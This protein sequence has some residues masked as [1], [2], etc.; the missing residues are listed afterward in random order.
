VRVLQARDDLGLALEPAHEVGVV[1]EFGMDG[2]DRDLAAHLGLERPVDQ[3]ERPLADLLEQP[4]APERLAPHLE[5]GVLPKDPLVQLLERAGGVD[6][7]LVGEQL[8]RPLERPK[9]VGLAVQAVEREHELA[10]QPL[11]KRVGTGEGLELGHRLRVPTELELGRDLLLDGLEPELL[12][13][14]DLSGE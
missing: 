11:A 4:V 12:E 6:A 2:L 8:P 13:P 10:P 7:E 9:R 1:G 14:R 5:R 3:A